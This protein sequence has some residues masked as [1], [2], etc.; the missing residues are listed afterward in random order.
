MYTSLAGNR[1]FSLR[2]VLMAFAAAALSLV[3]LFCF[4][5]SDPLT[6]SAAVSE[7]TSISGSGEEISAD[8][9]SRLPSTDAS[10]TLEGEDSYDNYVDIS[11]PAA[12]ATSS[13]SAGKGKTRFINKN[14]RLM[15]TIIYSEAG[16]ES[17]QGQLAVGIVIMNRKRSSLFP[18]SIKGVIY[19]KGQFQPTR[20]GSLN[21]HFN[22]YDSGKTKTK[23]WQS[24]IKAAKSAMNGRTYIWH[25]GKKKSLRSYYFFSV[26]LAG[27]RLQID[28]QQFK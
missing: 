17:F 5:D 9:G 11:T 23:A 12:A 13:T 2:C 28:H 8:N 6:A 24:C 15:S 25:K 10:E 19:Q 3:L 1:F 18:N 26:K 4:S 7:S 20:N 16:C 27:Y 22:E 14:L 21:R